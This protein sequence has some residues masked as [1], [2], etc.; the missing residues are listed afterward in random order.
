MRLQVGLVNALMHTQGYAAPETRASL[1]QARLLIEQAGAPEQPI[2]DTLLLLSVLNGFWL[3]NL[4]AFNGDTVRDLAAQFLAIA[5]K[6]VT[7]GPLMIGHR[8]M[9]SSLM[10]TG[11]IAKSREHFDRSLALYNAAK[12]R[13]LA[14]R[15]GIDHGSMS[16]W[17][18]S[19][20]LW[21]LGY[22]D[23]ALAD[24]QRAV[25]GARETG[26]AVSLAYALCLTAYTHMLCGNYVTAKAQSDELVRLA[27]EK[28]AKPL[29]VTGVINQGLVTIL[30]GNAREG[31]ELVTSGLAAYS[32]TGASVYVPY[33]LTH[34]V[35]AYLGLGEIEK[36][37]RCADDAMAMI[38]RT[39]ERVWEAEVHRCTGEIALLMPSWGAVKAEAHFERA[40]AVARQQQAK[41]WELRAAMSMA[42]L[43]RD[44]GKRAEARELL[45]PVY[46]WF[47]EGFDTLDLKEAK[48]LLDELAA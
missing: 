4:L 45:A 20:A 23:A 6:Q 3:A 2:E 21:F 24:A 8:L 36:A 40:L 12:H 44:Q 47:T 48:A 13:P 43:W 26:H 9:G 10:L 16:L 29:K 14:T 28:D 1:D 39:K 19:W 25:N 7:T 46:G 17:N 34:L 5:E 22:P 11:D 18:R 32:S 15:F 42:R 33:V 30:T 35:R 31:A 41:S 27:N 37:R 38:E